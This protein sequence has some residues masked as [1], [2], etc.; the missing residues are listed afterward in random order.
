MVCPTSQKINVLS[1]INTKHPTVFFPITEKKMVVKW[2]VGS[3][4]PLYS[5]ISFYSLLV[6]PVKASPNFLYHYSFNTSS[7]PPLLSYGKVST[8]SRQPRFSI[9]YFSL[10]CLGK[11]KLKVLHQRRGFLGGIAC[12]YI[13]ILGLKWLV[14]EEGCSSVALTKRIRMFSCKSIS[15][16]KDSNVSS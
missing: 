11:R 10:P 12:R 7:L 6:D 2:M 9:R 13:F 14:E 15:L 1:I 4:K 3:T 16:S 5:E 8:P